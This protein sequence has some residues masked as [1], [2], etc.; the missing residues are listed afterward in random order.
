[1]YSFFPSWFIALHPKSIPLD[2]FNQIQYKIKRK[3]LQIINNNFNY[4]KSGSRTMDRYCKKKKHKIKIYFKKTTFEIKSNHNH[5]QKYI[6]C[7]YKILRINKNA[8]DLKIGCGSIRMRQHIET[9]SLARMKWRRRCLAYVCVCE[10]DRH[11]TCDGQTCTGRIWKRSAVKWT[12]PWTP[13]L[14]CWTPIAM[15]PLLWY[16]C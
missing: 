14:I 16:L 15:P 5:Y 7:K 9:R 11:G 3:F 8:M 10:H 1:M 2:H 13:H 6:Q 4:Y 12:R